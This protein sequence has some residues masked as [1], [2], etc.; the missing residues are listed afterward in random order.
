MIVAFTPTD[1]IAI[2]GSAATVG[3]GDGLFEA[4]ES[5]ILSYDVTPNI[6]GLS[7]SISSELIGWFGCSYSERCQVAETAATISLTNATPILEFS[8]ATTPSL[9]FCDTVIYSFT[10]TNNTPETSPPGAA[11]AKDV[12]CLLYTSPSPRD[13]RGSRMPSSA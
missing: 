9:D 8:N 7:N 6:C 1:M 4:D 2:D 13:Q 3:D 12:T 5:F 10:I 11:Y